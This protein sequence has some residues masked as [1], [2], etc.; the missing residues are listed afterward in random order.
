VHELVSLG[1]LEGWFRCMESTP[2]PW[3]CLWWSVAIDGQKEVQ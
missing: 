2:S 3:I 1:D